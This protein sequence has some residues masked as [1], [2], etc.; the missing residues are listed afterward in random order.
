MFLIGEPNDAFAKYFTGQSYLAPLTN[1]QIP[2]HNVTFEPGCRNNWHMA[3][4]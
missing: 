4:G 2:I 3:S 1:E